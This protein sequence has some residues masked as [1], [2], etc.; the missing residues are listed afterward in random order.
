MEGWVCELTGGPGPRE[1]SQ[2]TRDRPGRQRLRPRTKGRWIK[3][4]RMV[5]AVGGLYWP[6]SAGQS[7]A[8]LLMGPNANIARG[9]R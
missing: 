3:M 4:E 2:T 9:L 8:S 1:E 6:R 7:L 5:P